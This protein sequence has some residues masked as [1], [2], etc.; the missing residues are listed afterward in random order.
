[1]RQWTIRRAEAGDIPQLDRLLCQVHRV[2][3]GIRP[4]LFRAGAKKYT[5]SQLE[6]ILADGSRPVFV[7]EEG[8]AVLGYAFCV[9]QQ[10]VGDPS[11]TEVKTLYIDD[12]CVDQAA[13]GRGVGRRLYQFVLDYAREQGCYNVT[14]NVW[15]GNEGAMAFY[16]AVGLGVQ[17]IGM[18]KIL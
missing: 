6:A 5:D 3:S 17:K 8:G 18:E 12:L 1:M 11:R 2:H 9:H 14:L 15:Q 16:R 10:Y 7:A 13:R 4:D